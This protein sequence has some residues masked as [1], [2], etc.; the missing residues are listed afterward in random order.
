ME[1]DRGA[2]RSFSL[3]A[4]FDSVSDKQ[5]GPPITEPDWHDLMS[6]ILDA[7]PA[8]EMKWMGEIDRKANK[9]GVRRPGTGATVLSKMGS[10]KKGSDVP[11]VMMPGKRWLGKKL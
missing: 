5:C 2:Q 4:E 10:V 7:I 3:T 9:E 8:D 11:G 6:R 1:C